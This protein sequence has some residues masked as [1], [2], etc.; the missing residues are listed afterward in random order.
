M[1]I[2]WE[3]PTKWLKLWTTLSL[4]RYVSLNE[5]MACNSNGNSLIA[6]VSA[7]G[8]KPFIQKDWAALRCGFGRLQHAKRT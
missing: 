2:S 5:A 7:V 3:C 1:N 4:K 6:F 8:D